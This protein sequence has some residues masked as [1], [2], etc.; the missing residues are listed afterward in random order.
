MDS[1]SSILDPRSS[2]P[3][4]RSSKLVI[5]LVGGM[6]SGKSQ[7][8]AE[9]SRRGGRVIS[10]DRLGHEALRQ[11][12]T[13]A[14][15]VERWGRG[16]LDDREEID[17]RKLGT[18]VFADAAQRRELEALVF[19]WI[20]RGIQREIAQA[21]ADPEVALIVLDAAIMIEA[22]WNK[23]CNRIVFV[24]AP[25]DI[26]WR[27]LAG[28]RGLS[29]KEVEMREAA[30]LSLAEKASRADDVIDNSGSSEQLARQVE[31]LLSHWSSGP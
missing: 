20:E 9:L 17:R 21:Q 15:I 29:A 4:P 25:Q 3:D 7:M 23:F 8:A 26:R 22:G 16:I 11:P 13:R 28:Q 1:R 18:I 12:D 14:R 31:K 2:K 19:P 6:G 27:R 24:D 30:Q 5:G 10:G